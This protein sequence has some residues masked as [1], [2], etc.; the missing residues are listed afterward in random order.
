MRWG[1]IWDN[2]ADR[3]HR[4]I[5]VARE[6]EPPTVDELNR[7]LGEARTADPVFHLFL[8][9]AATTGARRAQLLGLRGVTST[10][11]T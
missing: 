4:I 1:W 11:T 3:A 5:A 8:V 6:P 2:P 9:L 7:L 10:S